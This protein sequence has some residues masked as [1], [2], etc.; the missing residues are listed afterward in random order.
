MADR[1]DS[2]LLEAQNLV[3]GPR[4]DDY[5]HP[6]DDY[7]RVTG[8]FNALTGHNLTAEEGAIFMVCLKLSR[9]CNRP[10]RDNRTDGAGY[11]GVL[12]MIAS[13]RNLREGANG[14]PER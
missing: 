4:Q 3:H 14:K 13:E 5:G 8:A 12:D 6:F 11:F 7:S 9:E 1:D 2:I 10:K